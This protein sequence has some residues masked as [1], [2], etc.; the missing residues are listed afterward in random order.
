[1]KK[2]QQ[3]AGKNYSTEPTSHMAFPSHTFEAERIAISA[4]I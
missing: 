4:T 1:M 2:I 3:E